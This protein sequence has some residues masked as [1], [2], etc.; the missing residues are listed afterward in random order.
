MIH[1]NEPSDTENQLLHNVHSSSTTVAD[2]DAL[3]K[4]EISSKNPSLD[5]PNSSHAAV[6]QQLQQIRRVPL[7]SADIGKTHEST[8]APESLNNKETTSAVVTSVSQYELTQSNETV[9]DSLVFF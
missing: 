5:M 8:K 2:L 6:L 1:Q 9:I 7:I 4:L 3:E